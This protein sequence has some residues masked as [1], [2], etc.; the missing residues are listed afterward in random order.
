MKLAE[1][2][3]ALDI[4]GSELAAWPYELRRSA[5]RL[6]ASEPAAADC[7][8]QARQLD[9]LIARRVQAQTPVL[10]EAATRVLARLPRE[11]PRQRRF[12]LS[13]PLA[14]LDV[15]LAP[16][17]W[18]LAALAVVAFLGVAL[19]L[20]G[21]DIDASDAGWLPGAS[22]ETTLAVMFEPEPLTGVRP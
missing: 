10:D 18:R 9:R 21:P 7:L 8:E 1:L 12:A 4:Y 3:D 11:L 15:D 17:R 16:S 14:L 6:V 2:Q 22:A 19:G 13:W 5:E 20:F